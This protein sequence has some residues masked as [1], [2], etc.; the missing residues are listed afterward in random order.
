MM[1]DNWAC[2]DCGYDL[3]GLSGH[4]VVCPECG[5]SAD[6]DMLS[7]VAAAA[8]RIRQ[9][10]ETRTTI[11]TAGMW[12]TAGGYSVFLFSRSFGLVLFVA[13]VC[14]WTLAIISYVAFARRAVGWADALVSSHALGAAVA[15]GIALLGYLLWLSFNLLTPRWQFLIST[16]V[17][18]SAIGPLSLRQRSRWSVGAKHCDRVAQKLDAVARSLAF[19]RLDEQSAGSKMTTRIP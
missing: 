13:G 6:A 17:M 19:R 15:V 4:P 9:Q 10:L 8:G 18:L 1:A 14:T 3:N 11:C 2:P 16:L 12:I 5:C 7:Q